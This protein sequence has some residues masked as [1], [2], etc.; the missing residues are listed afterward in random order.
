MNSGKDTAYRVELSTRARRD[1]RAI[2]EY[3]DAESS[4]AAAKW[5]NRLEDLIFTLD[6]LPNRG[7]RVPEDPT[8]FQLLHG[9]KPHVYRIMYSIDRLRNRVLVV[10]I[11]HG[12]QRAFKPQNLR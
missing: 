11:R 1:L 4:T 3:I 2:A 10:H 12:A 9:N 6:R 5:F 7:A 8:L